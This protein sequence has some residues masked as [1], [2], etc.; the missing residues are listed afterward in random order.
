MKHQITVV[1]IALLLAA[2]AAAANTVPTAPRA[3]VVQPEPAPAPQ[4]QTDAEPAAE[5]AE[6]PQAAD[7]SAPRVSAVKLTGT[8]CIPKDKL[9]SLLQTRAGCAFDAKAL[10]QDIRSLEA[11]YHKCGYPLA[12]VTS[13]FGIGPDGVVTLPVDEGRIE[14]IVVKGARKTR[15]Y[16]VLREMASRVGDVYDTRKLAAD[17]K[18]LYGL[19]FFD[20]VSIAP[21][22]GSEPGRAALVVDV[23]ERQTGNMSAALG[24]GNSSGL[25]GYAQWS[26]TNLL[27]MGQTLVINWQRGAYSSL[28]NLGSN[29]NPYYATEARTGFDVGLFSPWLL[30]RG[31]S[32]GVRFYDTAVQQ[33]FYITQDVDPLN[34]KNY[35]WRKGVLATLSRDLGRGITLGL[36][37]RS[38]RVDYNVAPLGAVPPAGM[39]AGPSDVTSIRLSATRGA[40]SPFIGQQD[41]PRVGFS[42]EVGRASDIAGSGAFQKL[43][44]VTTN[45]LPIT[46]TDTLATRLQLGWS[47]GYVPFSELYSVG[48]A[49]TI[50]AYQYNKFLGTRMMVL[51]TEWRHDLKHGL[52]AVAFVDVGNAWGPGASIGFGS[53][54]PAVGLGLRMA[55][56]FGPIRFDYAIG[57]DGGRANLATGVSF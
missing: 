15:K 45:Y 1:C 37:G 38:D 56:P 41:G 30:Q 10:D 20:N 29:S 52:T 4:P 5:P 50:R 39:V 25:V 44:I 12:H 53:L 3:P 16:V 19:G 18:R 35:E 7:P 21:E 34:L 31:T 26:D 57:R 28:L 47:F 36:A 54:H 24:Y 23:K 13:G 55:S 14:K 33:F 6:Q 46:R 48:G 43:G 49:D 32:G 27:G 2:G 9:M 11:Y 40:I 17:R 22:A 51:N 42:L 8:R